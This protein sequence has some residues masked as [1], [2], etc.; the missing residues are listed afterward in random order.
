M[1]PT[2]LHKLSTM[3]NSLGQYKKDV[4]VIFI[5]LDPHRDTPKIADSYAKFF[6]KDFT[7]LSGDQNII[8]KVATAYGVVYKVVPSKSEGYL[9]DHS[10]NIYLI[11]NKS[12]KT[13]FTNENQNPQYMASYIKKLIVR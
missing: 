11:Y 2:V 12:L 13:V 9:I 5:T 10:D 8:K 4:K 7:G 1:C 6:N 3:Y